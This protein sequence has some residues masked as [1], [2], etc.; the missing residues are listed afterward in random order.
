MTWR[1]KAACKT[2]GV[3]VFFSRR[4]TNQNIEA[5]TFCNLCPVR[6]E[7]LSYAAEIE[8]EGLRYGVF[9]GVQAADRGP[10]KS[11]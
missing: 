7:C 11:A 2:Q 1:D 8:G 9:G 6:A 10:F 4:D 3:A 5:L